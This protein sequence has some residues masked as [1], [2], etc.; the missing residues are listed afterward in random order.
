MRVT[1]IFLLVCI[2]LATGACA[3]DIAPR[4]DF[5]QRLRPCTA[6]HGREGRPVS[7]GYYPR[8]AGKPAGYLYEQL[9]NFRDGRR[10][11]PMMSYMVDRQPEAYLRRMAE[12]FAQQEF[13]YAMPPVVRRDAASM[14]RGATL[15]R[16]GDAAHRIPACMSCHGRQL[17]GIAP[18]VPGLLGLPQYYLAAQLNSWRQGLRH[19]RAP[20]CMAEIAQALQAADVDA[21][22]AWLAAQPV[23]PDARA[24]LRAL[25]APLRCGSLEPR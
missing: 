16:Q 3:A 9:L 7:D 19:A 25:D 5:A 21:L 11:S 4:D 2:W 18:A 22:S 8:I 15:V 14:A 6:C 24:P 23:P 17:T 1:R 10:V 13:P 20:D 12:Y